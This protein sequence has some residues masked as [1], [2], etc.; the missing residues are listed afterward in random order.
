MGQ[1]NHKIKLAEWALNSKFSALQESLA[2]ANQKDILSF[3]LGLPS[4]EFF[5]KEKYLEAIAYLLNN[6]QL[7]LQYAPPLSSLKKHIISLMKLRGISCDESQVFLT[8]GAQQ[9]ISLLIK[10]LLEPK[11]PIIS[12]EFAYPGFLQ[13]VEPYQPNFITIKTD[14]TT[15]MDVDEVNRLL[16][17]GARPAFIYAIADGHNPLGTTMSYE[18]R[19]RLVKLATNFEIPIIEDDPYGLLHY[20]DM[21]LPLLAFEK[22]WVFYVGSFSKILAPSLRIGWIIAPENIIPKLAILKEGSDIN[23]STFNQRAVSIFLNDFSFEYHLSI[24]RSEYKKRRDA[25]Y[26]ALKQYFPLEAVYEKPHSGFFI[27]VKLPKDINT[28]SLLPKIIKSA[29]VAYIPGISFSVQNDNSGNN[30][31]RLNFSHCSVEEINYGIRRM[32]QLI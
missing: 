5:P 30:C 20:D 17:S 31:L 2:L 6:D 23:S 21:L 10:L 11:Q 16:S 9:G 1:H 18:K 15:G 29:Q 32:G 14:L 3:A 26:N 27:W 8:T 25:I 4:M 13:A 19:Q 7:A 22:N 28:Y 12:E 24:L